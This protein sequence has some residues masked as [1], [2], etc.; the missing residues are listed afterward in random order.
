MFVVFANQA[1]IEKTVDFMIDR[2]DSL[3][4]QFLYSPAPTTRRPST[5]AM[6]LNEHRHQNF[7]GPAE[8]DFV[9]Y[10]KPL[11]LGDGV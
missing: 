3:G 5:N 10:T 6:N 11:C 1:D 4:L 7:F 2:F 8:E 9:H